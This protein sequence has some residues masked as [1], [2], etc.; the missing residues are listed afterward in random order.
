VAAA[1]EC[2]VQEE[3]VERP[4]PKFVPEKVDT[5]MESLKDLAAKR[6]ENAK[7]QEEKKAE[8]KP[9]Q[10]NAEAKSKKTWYSGGKN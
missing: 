6:E 10:A 7:R 2:R 5:R 4:P 1:E 9:R 8:G 3:Y